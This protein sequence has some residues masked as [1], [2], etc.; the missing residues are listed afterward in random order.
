MARIDG[1]KIFIQCYRAIIDALDRLS[2]DK[3]CDQDA[4]Y[5]ASGMKSAIEK[6]GF[7]VALV[8]VERCLKCTKPLTLQLQNAS[9]NAGKAREKVSLLQQTLDELRTEINQTHSSFYEV[10]VNLA[11][12]ANIALS[13]P[14]TTGRQVHRENVPAQS[15]SDYFKKVITI[16]FLEKSATDGDAIL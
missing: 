9:R 12:E 10:A 16:P 5:R 7:I 4:R 14:R 6:F 2:K 3:S 11:E 8:V 1:L 15:T 13:K